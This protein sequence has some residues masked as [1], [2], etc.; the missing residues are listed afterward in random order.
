M[1]LKKNLFVWGTK[2]RI[3]LFLPNPDP[4]LWLLFVYFSNCRFSICIILAPM[5]SVPVLVKR[6]KYY[7]LLVLIKMMESWRHASRFFSASC[8][9]IEINLTSA[10][11]LEVFL[12][13]FPKLYQSESDVLSTFYT[14]YVLSKKFCPILY[15]TIIHWVNTS[16]TYSIHKWT[17]PLGHNI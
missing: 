7:W 15:N 4:H 3:R 17:R 1:D 13:G 9:Y 5:D 12:G 2:P 10:P 16:W 11:I 14:W 6:L 8:G